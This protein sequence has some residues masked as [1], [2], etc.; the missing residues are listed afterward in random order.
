MLFLYSKPPV[1]LGV[2]FCFCIYKMIIEN[3]KNKH[4]SKQIVYNITKSTYY[5]KVIDLQVVITKNY[6]MVIGK[7]ITNDK[8]IKKS[9][10]K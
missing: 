5:K 7:T 10:K 2:F 6:R 9:D 8:T 3:C 1:L 4:F